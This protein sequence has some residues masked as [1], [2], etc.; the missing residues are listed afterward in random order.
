MTDRFGGQVFNDSV[1][2]DYVFNDYVTLIESTLPGLLNHSKIPANLAQPMLYALMAGG[3]RIRP[4]LTLLTAELLGS[5]R[6][7]ALKT[8]CAVEMIHTYSLIHDDLPAMDDDDLRRGKPTL[9]IQFDEALAILAGDGLQSLAFEIIAGDNQLSEHCR[10]SLIQNI[11]K[12]VGPAGMVA[13]QVLDMAGEKSAIDAEQL[14][15]MHNRKTGDLI[16]ASVMAGATIAGANEAAQDH[17]SQFGYR[18]G[19]AF[20]V[21]DDLLDVLSDTETLGKPQGSDQRQDKSTFTS[22]FGIDG[23]KDRLKELHHG[24]LEALTPFGSSAEPL[25]AL[26]Q[27]V[28]DRIH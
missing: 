24:A 4:T 14:V 25:K 7:Q 27:F 13:G 19:L 3:K 12:A 16:A 9:H 18:L 6:E 5:T 10:L 22:I 8:A 26:T 20:Q 15:E 1:F 17:L 2:K 23:A 21:R 28:V 11:S